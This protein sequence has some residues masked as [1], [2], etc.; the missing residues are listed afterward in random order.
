MGAHLCECKDLSLLEVVPSFAVPLDAA[1]LVPILAKKAY[2]TLQA[3]QKNLVELIY[4]FLLSITLA[5][6]V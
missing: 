2:S 3:A 6:H 1:Q 4:D 5:G